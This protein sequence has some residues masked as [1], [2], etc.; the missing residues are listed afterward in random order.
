MKTQIRF[1]VVIVMVMVFATFVAA[2]ETEPLR[3]LTHDSFNVSEDVLAT[4]EEETGITVE[5]LRAG[6]AGQVVNQAILAAGNPLGDV[7]YGVDNT[8]LSRAL[9]SDLFIPY[10]SPLLEH[11]DETYILDEEHSVTPVDYGDVCL[12]YDIGYFEENGLAVPES[13][14]ALT[15]EAYEGLLVVQN[16]ATSSPGLAFLLATIA[17]FGT[18][19]DYTYLDY[20]TDLVENDVLI[21]DGWSD[22]YYTYFTAGSE[23]GTYPLVVSYASSPPVTYDEDLDAATTASVVADGMCFRQIEFAGILR[24]TEN[25]EAAQQ[26]IDF[27]LSTDFQED[28]PL[29]M[30][31]FPVNEEAELPEL[32]ADYAQ[33]PENPVTV[34]ATEIEENREAWIEAWTETVLR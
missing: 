9:N 8:F 13:L 20:W 19:G 11:V 15:E 31:V 12:N 27:L 1:I 7:I 32:F 18:E 5:I 21:T 24:G 33:I 6:D 14:S 10:E 22:A 29:Q 16:P 30:Y 17:E 34:D 28:L 25:E 4:F 26:F 23:D 3:V 2:Q